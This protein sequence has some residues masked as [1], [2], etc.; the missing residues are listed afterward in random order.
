MRLA[1]EAA[2]PVIL[3]CILIAGCSNEKS[4]WLNWKAAPPDH[5]GTAE[6]IVGTTWDF[7]PNSVAF[8][9]DGKCRLGAKGGMLM[10]MPDTSWSINDGVVT[11]KGP[12]GTLLTATWDGQTLVANG[13]VGTQA[14]MEEE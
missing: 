13:F 2:A 4:S 8:E 10:E 3:A 1:R 14:G 7:G 5:P 12:N 11:V 6:Q 9:A